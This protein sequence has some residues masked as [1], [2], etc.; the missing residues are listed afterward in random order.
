MPRTSPTARTDGI[1]WLAFVKQLHVNL[2]WVLP[3]GGGSS[4]L[5]VVFARDPGTYSTF[6]HFFHFSPPFIFTTALLHCR[7][8]SLTDTAL[9]FQAAVPFPPHV[10]S[11]SC[12]QTVDLFSPSVLRFSQLFYI[13]CRMWPKGRLCPLRNQIYWLR[14]CRSL[15]L[16]R[17]FSQHVPCPVVFRSA[18]QPGSLPSLLDPVIFFIIKM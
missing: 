9:Y 14:A 2:T 12:P 1:T 15:C 7:D 6:C 8:S 17:T 10:R 11:V 3:G 4:V 16:V 5:S 13:I 18:V